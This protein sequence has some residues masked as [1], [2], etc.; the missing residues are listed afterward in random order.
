[1][2]HIF[3]PVLA[4]LCLGGCATVPQPTVRSGECKVIERPQYVVRGLRRYDQDW[5]DSTI[6]GGVGA[7]GWQRPAPRPASLDEKLIKK[8]VPHHKIKPWLRFLR[9]FHPKKPEPVAVTP[10]ADPVPEPPAP[11][12]RK[13]IDELLGTV[14]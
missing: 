3:L 5:I 7:C 12:P 9:A 14:Q 4:L 1:M 6:E 10:I 8:A 2:K 11:A 13:P